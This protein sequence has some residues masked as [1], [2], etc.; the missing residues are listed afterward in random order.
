MSISSI[1]NRLEETFLSSKKRILSSV[2]G[3][4]LLLSIPVTLSLV[5]QQQDIR[6]RAF[7]ED[8]GTPNPFVNPG[9]WGQGTLPENPNASL[10][11]NPPTYFPVGEVCPGCE[12]GFYVA[13]NIDTGQ[14]VPVTRYVGKT[15]AEAE[16]NTNALLSQYGSE[17]I[18]TQSI[19]G[20]VANFFGSL[21]GSNNDTG[22]GGGNP[23]PS[24]IQ[25]C[26]NFSGLYPTD[27]SVQYNCYG[28]NIRVT[29]YRRGSNGILGQ[30]L[31]QIDCPSGT[32]CSQSGSSSSGFACVSCAAPSQSSPTSTPTPTQGNNNGCLGSAIEC[33]TPSPTVSPTPT[34]PTCGGNNSNSDECAC[35]SNIQCRQGF[36]CIDGKC[37]SSS[38]PTATPSPTIPASPND[39]LLSLKLF[40][41]GVGG[42]APGNNQTPNN[43]EKTFSVAVFNNQ[44]N[45]IKTVTQNLEYGKGL[46]A[47]NNKGYGGKISLGQIPNG[48]Y[49]A[50][51]R[52]YNS[53]W[54]QI[55][56][57]VSLQ[58]ATSSAQYELTLTTGDLNQDNKMGIE[59]YNIFLTCFAGD[60][61]S[62]DLKTMSDLNNDGNI[63]LKDLNI[64]LRGFAN[65]QGD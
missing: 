55:P 27:G 62:D 33:T 49:I 35:T 61:C 4:I 5:Y 30:N 48:N 50:K 20:T 8:S 56:G 11:V 51:I 14:F 9:R 32:A 57:F 15:A 10:L 18:A 44:N 41:P 3:I 58:Q 6:Q 42:T 37:T 13:I 38:N 60:T 31:S 17:K 40:I 46:G 22:S 63:D 19:G 54:K 36:T 1:G 16:E 64:L 21:F 26:N 53:L 47:E 2:V 52:T 28:S 43:L 24:P 23:T 25:Y 59:D 65:R 29:L 39:S 45:Q 7:T 12:A 34:L